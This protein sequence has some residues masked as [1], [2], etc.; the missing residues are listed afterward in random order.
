M[1]RA[2]ARDAK[3]PDTKA[4]DEERKEENLKSNWTAVSYIVY[5]EGV[6]LLVLLLLVL[7]LSGKASSAT[8]EMIVRVSYIRST[9]NR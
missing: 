9:Y 1:R 7:L 6:E 3:A 4:N 2:P 5:G 8:D